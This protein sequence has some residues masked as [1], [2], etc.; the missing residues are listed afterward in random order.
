MLTN[1]YS[2]AVAAP[3]SPR[4]CVPWAFWKTV[5]IHSAVSFLDELMVITNYSTRDWHLY[6]VCCL[7][8][9]GE[10]QDEEEE[11]G[12]EITSWRR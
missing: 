6:A 5:T 8:I 2:P 3:P 11:E 9:A 7:S 4:L 12:Q 1:D 10:G